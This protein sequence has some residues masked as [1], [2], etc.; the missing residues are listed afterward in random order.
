MK[1]DQADWT[2][3][4]LQFCLGALA[5][6]VVTYAL[7]WWFGILIGQWAYLFGV[8]AGGALLVGGQPL[9]METASGSDAVPTSTSGL[10]V[11]GAQDPAKWPSWWPSRVGP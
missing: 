11:I 10:V 2:A 3:W 6:A 7:C 9:T 5:G 8:V 1:E 4:V